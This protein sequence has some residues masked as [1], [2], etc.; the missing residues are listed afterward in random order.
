MRNQLETLYYDGQCPLFNAE[1]ARLG[2]HQPSHLRLID[3]HQVEMDEAKKHR[4][5][6]VLHLE[7]ADG[8]FRTGLEANIAAW[9]HTRWGLAW[10]W[11]RLPV[12]RWFAGKV[13]NAWAEARYS[14]LYQ[15]N[16]P[17]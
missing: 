17:P 4:M 6:K 1:M 12:I 14:R 13:Y 2:A 16:S 15:K 11:L 5:L 9:E 7:A 10:Q 8:T 3:I